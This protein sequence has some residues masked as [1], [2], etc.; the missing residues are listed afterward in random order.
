VRLEVGR[1]EG[2]VDEKAW[3]ILWVTDFPMFE[4]HEED[5]RYYA[6][7]HPFTS[8]QDDD[9]DKL[10]ADRAAVHAKAYDLVL[11]GSEIGGGSIR[12]HRADIQSRVF[13]RWEW[14]AAR[15]AKSSVFS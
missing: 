3:K 10:E 11:N 5:K 9:I 8:P 14:T 6:L 15:L 2:L 13:L 12:I 4:Y 7:H 1:R